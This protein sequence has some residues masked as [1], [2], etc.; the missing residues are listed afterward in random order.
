[1]AGA[2]IASPLPALATD[3]QPLDGWG[4]Q[5]IAAVFIP[6]AFVCTL[7]F[8]W[9]ALQPDADSLTGAAYLGETIDAPPE[10]GGYVRRS[11][12]TG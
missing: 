6:W 4:A 11:V 1:V 5:E 3:G 2:I 12:E 8:E 10:Q 7:F 9:E